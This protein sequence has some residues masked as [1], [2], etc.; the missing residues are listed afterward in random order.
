V[1]PPGG[2]AGDSAWPHRV[3]IIGAGVMGSSLAAVVGA[4]IPPAVRPKVLLVC[5]NP[6]AA[7]AIALRGVTTF[8]LLE[9]SSRPQVVRSCTGLADAGGVDLLFIA[10]KTCAIPE[11]AQELRPLLSRIG[12]GGTAPF[13]VSYQNGIDPGRQLIQLLAYHRVLRMV[14]NFGGSQQAPG[15]I[16]V[17]MNQPPHAIGCLDPAHIPTCRVIADLLTAG[18][19]ETQ[20][21]PEIERRVWT[22]G[23]I[24]AAMN[25]VAALIDST[26]GQV[27]DSPSAPIVLRL[28][29]EGFDVARAEGVNLDGDHPGSFIRRAMDLLEHGRPHTPSMVQ[30]IRAG[31]ISEV[32]QLN[33]QVVRHAQAAGVAVPTH[34]V[35]LGLIEAF[36]WKTYHRAPPPHRDRSEQTAD[37]LVARSPHH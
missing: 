16:R 34:E 24:N 9:C 21:E 7:E 3:G 1:I 2:D 4:G 36:D 22:K 28:L 19:L 5:R 6:G 11:V 33:R 18:G 20:F 15:Q 17:G 32:G 23:V 31:R 26:V 14:L 35:I 27:L 13:I 30:D 12:R 10:T 37:P 25:P 29:Q 8:G